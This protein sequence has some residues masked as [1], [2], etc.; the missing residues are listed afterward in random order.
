LSALE[1]VNTGSPIGSGA[2]SKPVLTSNGSSHIYLAWED[3]RNVSR[4]IYFNFWGSPQGPIPALTDYL[5]AFLGI[6]LLVFLFFIFRRKAE[7]M[8]DRLS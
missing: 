1:R 6:V 3:T 8:G 5:M 2:A 7:G 4:D